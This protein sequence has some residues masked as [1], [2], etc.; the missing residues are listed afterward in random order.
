[1]RWFE[2]DKT[3]INPLYGQCC[4]ERDFPALFSL[5]HSGK[6]LLDELVSRTYK[7]EKVAEAFEHMLDGS[8]AKGVILLDQSLK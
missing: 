5:Y 4:P 7:L 3:Y 1:M 2:W 8:N 6:L